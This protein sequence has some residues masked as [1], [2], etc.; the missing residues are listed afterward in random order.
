MTPAITKVILIAWTILM[1]TSPAW[2]LEIRQDL[3]IYSSV[4]NTPVQ[5]SIHQTFIIDNQPSFFARPESR[6]F[7]VAYFDL[8]SASLSPYASS[9]LLMDLRECCAACP[10]YLTGYTCFLGVENQNLKLSRHR[11]ETVAALLRKNGYKVASVEGK[12]MIYGNNPENNRRVEIR[13]TKK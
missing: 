1:L 3:Y 5:I 9:K 8:G 4:I 13:L 11:A 10:L 6:P 7:P 2:G 12:G